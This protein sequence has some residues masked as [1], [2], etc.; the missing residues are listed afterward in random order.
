MYASRKTAVDPAACVRA[1]LHIPLL[2]YGLLF[3]CVRLKC[4]HGFPCVVRTPADTHSKSPRECALHDLKMNKQK[5]RHKGGEK[6][7]SE[8]RASALS[9]P[10]PLVSA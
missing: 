6:A 9:S 7:A 10:L 8:P 2:R 4:L 3:L 5:E 1:P